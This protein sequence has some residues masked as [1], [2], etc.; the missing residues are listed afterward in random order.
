MVDDEISLGAYRFSSKNLN[1]NAMQGIYQKIEY[2]YK[3]Y[4]DEEI[5]KKREE[6]ITYAENYRNNL[7]NSIK[8][9]ALS[10]SQVRSLYISNYRKAREQYPLGTTRLF[11]A[12]ITKITGTSHQGLYCMY[13]DND[14]SINHHYKIFTRNEEFLNIVPGK[15]WFRAEINDF[16]L[17]SFGVIGILE[18]IKAVP[19]YW[20]SY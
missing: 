20:E 4:L 14:D 7:I 17:D 9:E 13:I 2:D 8:N 16:Y 11:E 19:I 1:S 3:D 6:L 10:P 18:L 5:P 12:K 15:V